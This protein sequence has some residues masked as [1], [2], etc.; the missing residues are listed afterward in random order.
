MKYADETS[1]TIEDLQVRIEKA[2]RCLRDTSSLPAELEDLRHL[3]PKGFD[4]RVSLI[5]SDSVRKIRKIRGN[6]AVDNWQP[7]NCQAL[8]GYERG[9]KDAYEPDRPVLGDQTSRRLIR[10]KGIPL[11]QTILEGRR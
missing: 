9:K 2:L 1:R 10:I 7:G 11:S 6:A 4:P 5:R 8:I 3:A